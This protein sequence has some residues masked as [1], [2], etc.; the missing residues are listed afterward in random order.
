MPAREIT[1]I[2]DPVL[3]AV[4][5]DLTAERLASAEVQEL[6]DDLIDS[7]R[8]EHG[9]GIAAPQIGSQ[10]NICIIGVDN[11]ERYPYKPKIPL[12]VLVNPVVVVLDDATFLNNEG[13]LSVPLRG[14]LMRNMNIEVTSLDRTG[15]ESV[16]IYRGLT[17]GTVQH[18]IDHLAGVLIVDRFSDTR[19]ISTWQNFQDRELAEFV[20]RIQPVI[21][22]TEPRV[23]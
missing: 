3:R 16:S 18:E 20:E 22:V 8:S 2:G 11:N 21:D 9:A 19:S 10:L 17:A 4:T 15:I 6:V 12:T 14:D 5:T 23:L 7:M 1:E 13:C